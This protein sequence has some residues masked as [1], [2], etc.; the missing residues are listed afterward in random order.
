MKN[1][2][3]RLSNNQNLF[4]KTNK[5]QKREKASSEIPNTKLW[6]GICSW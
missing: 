6:H 2:E 1:K 3:L 4:T 5:K